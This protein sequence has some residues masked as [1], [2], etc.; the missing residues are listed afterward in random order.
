[1]HIK[2]CGIESLDEFRLLERHGIDFAGM[3]WQVRG[4]K[5]NL[6]TPLLAD[7]AAAAT[8]RT[9]PMVVTLGAP[10][11]ALCGLLLE[12]GI[13]AVQLHGFELPGAVRRIKSAIA[14]AMVFKVL[15]VKDGKCLEADLMDAYRHAGV[16]VFIA[17]TFLSRDAVGSTGVA[18]DAATVRGL[19]T[20]ARGVPVMLAGGVDAR[21]IASL[22]FASEL[23]GVDVDSAARIDGRIADPAVTALMMAVKLHGRREQVV[24][25]AQNYRY[26]PVHE[27]AA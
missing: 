21:R 5:Y 16:D 11:D 25:V 10:P 17:D 8:G 9:K 1:M 12:T 27:V 4:G 20:A 26:L 24:E 23:W 15:H 6:S 3:W 19:V 13:R 22:G 2:I 18:M 7:I 14:D